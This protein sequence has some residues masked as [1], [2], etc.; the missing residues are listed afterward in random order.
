[1]I[2]VHRSDLEKLHDVLVAACHH[3]VSRDESNAALHLAPTARF[4]PLTSEL[5]AERERVAALL[6]E[7]D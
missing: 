1:L 2:E 6:K 4:S 7:N 5:M 3:H